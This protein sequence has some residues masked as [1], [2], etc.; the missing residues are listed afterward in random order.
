VLV[1]QPASVNP[2]GYDLVCTSD[3]TQDAAEVGGVAIMAGVL[4][5][6]ASTARGSLIYD[7]NYGYDLSQWI[8]ADV[9]V[10][11]DIAPIGAGLDAEFLKDPRVYAS[12][13]VVTWQTGGD[14]L[15]QLTTTTQ[16]TLAAGPTFQLVLG[17]S[18]INGNVQILS[19]SPT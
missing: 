11:A 13:T 5:R 15:G 18:A 7:Q 17:V 10:A 16:V 6:R 19:V 4:Y 14:N 2:Y 3:L 1:T 12:T 9:N 8:N